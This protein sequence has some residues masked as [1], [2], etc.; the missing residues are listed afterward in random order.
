MDKIKI[1]K[2]QNREASNHNCYLKTKLHQDMNK[3]AADYFKDYSNMVTKPKF[4]HLTIRFDYSTMRS[5]LPSERCDFSGYVYHGLWL[6]MHRRLGIKHPKK[7]KSGYDKYAFLLRT[8]EVIENRDRWGNP[9]DEHYH[10]ICAFHPAHHKKVTKEYWGYVINS[11]RPFIFKDKS[12]FYEDVIHSLEVQ[13]IPVPMKVNG[14]AYWKDW[15]QLEA[16]LDYDNK[17]ASMSGDL[18]SSFTPTKDAN[19]GRPIITGIAS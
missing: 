16:V 11:P 12:Y 7:I 15:S 14:Y 9:T 3:E 13:E 4:Y 19:Y 5:L 17:Q 6:R 8:Y 1:S 2:F 10:I 18:F